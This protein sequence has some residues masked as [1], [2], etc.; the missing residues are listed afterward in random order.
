[1]QIL[2]RKTK[3]TGFT[4]IVWNA[5]ERNGV[6]FDAMLKGK[7]S[8]QITAMYDA[9]I[10]WVMSGAEWVSSPALTTFEGPERQMAGAAQATYVSPGACADILK[11]ITTGFRR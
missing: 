6:E 5:E 1:M 7:R 10:K 8:S 11:A 4:V 9:W 3:D 2:D